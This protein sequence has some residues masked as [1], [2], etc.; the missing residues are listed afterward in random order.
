MR[1]GQAIHIYQNAVDA[2]M[3]A[4]QGAQWWADVGAE[5]AAVIAAPDTA[6]AAGIIAWW[7]V[8]WRRVGQTPLRV[9]GRIR[10]HAA[11]VLND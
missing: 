1:Q 11:R 10:R 6:T 8:D 4:E 9:A 5:L 2:T 3:G 7:H